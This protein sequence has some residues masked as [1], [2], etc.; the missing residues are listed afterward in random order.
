MMN[1]RISALILSC[2]M[3]F[4]ITGCSK[5]E[6]AQIEDTNKKEVAIELPGTWATDFSRE[7][8]Q[9]FYKSGLERVESA[10]RFYGLNDIYEVV[11][12]EITTEG[13][14]SV[15]N[16]YIY[17][18]IENP[19]ANRLESMYYG[20]KQFG[21]N[22]ASG[23]LSMKLSMNLDKQVYI[24]NGNFKFEETSLAKFSEAFTNVVGRD[25]TAINEAIFN[26]INGTSQENT[27]ETNL[28]GIKETISI[29]D[30]FIIYRLETKEY[31]F[32]K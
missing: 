2:M 4:S 17:L 15:N 28:D 31:I 29:V 7:E 21:S 12:D 13:D 23:Q 9:E 6:E 22:L 1:K 30:D 26:I 24:T 27:I 8:V 25:Y 19:E 10:V 18:D 5:K 11:E 14:I 32:N 20:F 3:A 16:S